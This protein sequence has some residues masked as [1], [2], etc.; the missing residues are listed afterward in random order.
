MV[1]PTYKFT[2]SRLSPL[3]ITKHITHN[4]KYSLTVSEIDASYQF[5]FYGFSL[6]ESVSSVKFYITF[7][8]VNG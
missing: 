4:H 1:L 5:A 7:A 6:I 2:L 3:S 8:T